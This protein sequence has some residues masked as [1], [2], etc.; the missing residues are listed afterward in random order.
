MIVYHSCDYWVSRLWPSSTILKEHNV[1]K[2]ISVSFLRWNC[3]VTPTILGSL[4]RANPNPMIEIQ[5][6]K[7][8]VLSQY[9]T[10]DTVQQLRNPKFPIAIYIQLIYYRHIMDICLFKHYAMMMYVV[11][12][13]QFHHSARHRD[14]WS[15]SRSCRFTSK[16]TDLISIV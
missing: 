3:G 14:E 13:I 6:P 10:V 7:F 12:E 1:S 4:E 9:Q 16:K 2:T 11:A 15:A 8:C 5:F